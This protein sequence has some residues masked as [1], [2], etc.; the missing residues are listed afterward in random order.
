MISSPP[1]CPLS[2][3]TGLHCSWITTLPEEPKVFEA[4]DVR[5][6]C[7]IITNLSS[8][9]DAKNLPFDDHLTQFTQAEFNNDI[10]LMFV[11]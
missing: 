4:P 10:E 8:P 9:P 6:V 2:V 3:C 5:L 1:E 7:Q 11:C